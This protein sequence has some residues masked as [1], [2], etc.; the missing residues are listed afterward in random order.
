MSMYTFGI[1][2]NEKPID[3]SEAIADIPANRT[4]IVEKLT[5]DDALEPELAYDLK[6][7]EEVFAHY[8]PAVKVE[9]ETEKGEIKNEE[10]KFKNVGDFGTKSI[11]NQSSFLK[12]LE[13]R[14]AQLDKMTRQFSTNKVLINAL[15]DE[16]TR[17]SMI[18]VL[19]AALA[20][21]K[22]AK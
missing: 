7:I 11:V 14:Q 12:D 1:G 15:N 2:G 8:K 13:V 16:A 6:T 21:L 9:F 17:N 5:D 20:E 22:N 18:D 19:E 10:L 4:I 3:A